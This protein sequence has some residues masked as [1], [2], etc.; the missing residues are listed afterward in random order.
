MVTLY[1]PNE[2]ADKLKILGGSVWVA[3]QLKKS[4]IRKRADETKEAE[5]ESTEEGA[6]TKEDAKP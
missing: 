3:K 2:L 1:L 4:R 5:A 6:E